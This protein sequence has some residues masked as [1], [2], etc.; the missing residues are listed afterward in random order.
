MFLKLRRKFLSL[1]AAGLVIGRFGASSAEAAT[2]SESVLMAHDQ[3]A[4]A[5]DEAYI[6]VIKRI[7]K[8]GEQS[9]KKAVWLE[10]LAL[11]KP[12][13]EK[14]YAAVYEN[15]PS[16]SSDFKKRNSVAAVGQMQ[17]TAKRFYM[18]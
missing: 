7:M 5:I 16:L 15:V 9:T 18:L 12:S 2:P 10:V 4:V 8:T 17:R 1:A 11:A 3:Y 14:Y 6:K 13:E